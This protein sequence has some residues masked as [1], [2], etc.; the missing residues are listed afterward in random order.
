MTEKECIYKIILLGDN[1]VGKTSILL[2]YVDRIFREI[3]MITIGFDQR[4]KSIILKNWKSIKL[5][6]W[7]TAGQ[8]RFRTITK[9]YYKG[10]HGI[11]LIYDVTDRRTFESIRNWVS[12]IRE[13]AAEKVT[14]YLVANKIDM[15]E[16]R[17][18]EREEGEK[19][20]K[21]LGLPFMEVSAKDG[22]NVDEIFED[23]VERIYKIY[24]DDPQSFIKLS[25][26][27]SKKKKNCEKG[28]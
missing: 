17:K 11:I 12:I 27:K 7:D 19:L 22:I 2:R 4:L 8:D 3:Y 6:I 20:A 28:S 1:P 24:G 21:E 5:Q 26:S 23:L 25:L 14:I 10:M 15:K 9:H 13:V 18:V 16:N